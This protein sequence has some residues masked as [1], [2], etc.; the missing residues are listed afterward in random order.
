MSKFTVTED[1]I[2]DLASS[3]QLALPHAITITDDI[4]F[5]IYE[6]D[7]I[8]DAHALFMHGVGAL[9]NFDNNPNTQEQHI[10]YDEKSNTTEMT[11]YRRV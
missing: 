10:Q 11:I 9:W 1:K 3:K 6:H 8:D 2:H 4:V 7:Q 5:V